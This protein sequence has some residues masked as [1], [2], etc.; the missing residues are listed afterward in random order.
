MYAPERQ[1]EIVARARAAG[2]VDV[3]TLAAELDVAAETVRRDLTVLERRGLLRRVHGG[4]VPVER[5][6]LEPSVDERD[7]ANTD[8]KDAIARAALALLDD[9]STIVIDGG[10]T[11]ARL[12]ALLPEGREL[13]VITHALPVAAAVATR[14]GITLHLVGG[15][16]RGRTLVATGPWTTAALGSLRA[17]VVVL[18]ANGVS[19][20]RGLTTPDLAEAEA[21][22]AL[23]AAGRRVIVLADHTK[24]GRD[25]LVAFATIESVDTLVT[26]A[27]V[28]PDLLTELAAA[29]VGVVTA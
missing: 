15:H 13:T 26:D 22:R 19:V 28:D 10:T 23:A 6:T 17:D 24:I 25:E 20:D 5:L 8:A 9:A 29:G 2:R 21:K 11:T 12:A 18:G 1:N 7:L 16:V 27:G 3:A 14:P 4:A